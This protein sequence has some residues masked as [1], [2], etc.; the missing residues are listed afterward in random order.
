MPHTLHSTVCTFVCFIRSCEAGSRVVLVIVLVI[1][2]VLWRTLTPRSS[3]LNPL[4]PDPPPLCPHPRLRHEPITRLGS[5]AAFT[6]NHLAYLFSGRTRL[7]AGMA[8]RSHI[9]TVLSVVVVMEDLPSLHA[10]PT[11]LSLSLSLSLCLSL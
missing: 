4:T 6:L 2:V 11:S 10:G 3:T 1:V 5:C 7:L 9:Y 8:S